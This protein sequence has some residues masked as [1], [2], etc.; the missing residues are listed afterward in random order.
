MRSHPSFRTRPIGQSVSQH[1]ERVNFELS[2]STDIGTRAAVL[3][4]GRDAAPSFFYVRV[5][6]SADWFH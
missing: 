4:F 6:K 3:L 1:F 5:T 2:V